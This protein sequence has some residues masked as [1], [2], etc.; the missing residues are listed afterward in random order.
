MPLIILALGI[1]LL[2]LLIVK[3]KLNG[4]LSLIVVCLVVGV[5]EGLPIMKLMSSIESGI[6]GTLGHLALVLGLGAMLGRLMADSGGAQRISMTLIEK[7]G[8]KNVRWA[9][10]LTGFILG[11]ALF[12]EV[13]FVLLIPIV[14]TIAVAADIPVLEVGIPMAAAL[15][16]THCFLPPH[17]GPTAISIIFNADI[18]KTLLYGITI[19]IPTVIIA[20]PLLYNSVKHFKTEIPEGLISKKIFKE[21]ELPS[22]GMSCFT[23][24]IPVILMASSS[25][26]ALILPK[27]SHVYMFFNFVGAPGMALLIA[28]FV[29]LYT[30]GF[31]RNIK[32]TQ[33]MKTV[34]SSVSS[35]AMILLIIGGGGAFKQ[36]LIDSGV[37]KYIATVMVG[38]NISPLILGWLVACVL[39]IAVGSA[40]VAG[41]TAAGIVMPLIAQTHVSP[42]LMVLAVG[43]GTVIGGPPNDPGFWMFKEFFNLSI[44]QT[45]RSWCVM[46]TIIA[47]S[48]IIGV[49]LL[50]LVV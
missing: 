4:F 26:T 31:S 11:I 20:G 3:F 24:L 12:Y 5:A 13:G 27:K 38:V 46:E 28:V 6:G 50:S 7:F 30:F 18:G 23:A 44:P 48:G 39:R 40:T 42:E 35:I 9:V 22:F 45:V 2:F 19:A 32:I 33:L 41:L 10:T 29:A 8:R 47:V 37:G 17:P 34:E 36:V 14:F 1:V 15:S 21:E 16:V 49:M 25:I 43:A